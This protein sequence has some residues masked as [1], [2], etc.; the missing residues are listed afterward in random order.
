MKESR[1]LT[2]LPVV[3]DQYHHAI[4]VLKSLENL[5]AYKEQILTADQIQKYLDALNQQKRVVEKFLVEI[6]ECYGAKTIDDILE[7]QNNGNHI[8]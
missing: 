7:E 2:A 3:F 5:F 6:R 1:N 8:Q 4:E